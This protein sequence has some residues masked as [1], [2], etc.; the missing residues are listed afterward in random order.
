PARAIEKH[1]FTNEQTPSV[2]LEF[3]SGA[4]AT[5][6]TLRTRSTHS[7]PRGDIRMRRGSGRVAMD[8]V[9]GS[10]PSRAVKLQVALLEENVHLLAQDLRE[11][12]RLPPEQNDVVGRGYASVVLGT[13]IRLVK[14]SVGKST[15]IAILEW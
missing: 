7:T 3:R 6:P 10:G 8:P 13:D 2:G 5:G 4:V 14:K 12:G 15:A 11:G 9:F 1:F